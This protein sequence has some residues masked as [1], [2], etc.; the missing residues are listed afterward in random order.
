MEE[1][2][3]KQSSE[4]VQ[5]ADSMSQIQVEKKRNMLPWYGLAGLVLILIFAG[6]FYQMNKEGRFASDGSDIRPGATIATVNG[7]KIKG[8]DLNVSIQQITS[9]AQL[10]G[11]DVTD[12]SVQA[13]IQAQAVEMLVNTEL[14]KQEAAEKGIEITEADVDA[15]IETLI[16]ELGGEDVLADRMEQLGIDEDSLR[17]DIHS[18]LIIQALL[19]DVFAEEAIEVTDEE[20]ARV[21]D[22]QGG[23][24]SGLPEFEEIQEQLEAQIRLS[25]EQVVVDE[26]I[27][28]LRADAEIEVEI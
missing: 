3:M 7:V 9:A 14:L 4:P 24:E 15:R 8:S 25:K 23:E 28:D 1:Q 12:P 2:E 11:V 27:Q 16:A 22:V 26:F 20:V 5:S 21:Y 6:L 10:Q 18:E 17:E 19:D 13:D